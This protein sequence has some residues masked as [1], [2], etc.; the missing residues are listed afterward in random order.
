MSQKEGLDA[1]GSSI[2]GAPFVV[3][4]QNRHVTWGETT[5][6]FDVT[7]TYQERIQALPPGPNGRRSSDLLR[8][9]CRQLEHGHPVRHVPR[10][11]G[12]RRPARQPVVACGRRGI[13]PVVLTVPRRNNGPIVDLRSIG[14]RRRHGDQRPVHRFQRHARARDVPAAQP[15]AQRHEFV[16]ALQY[17]DVG[18][19][20]F[21]YGDIDGNIGYFSTAK[22]RCART[23][24]PS[25][26]DGSPPWFIRNGQGGNEWLQ[27]PDPTR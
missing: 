4:G 9:A 17:F 18:S 16:A 26:V 19:Q 1:I 3:L 22:C 10:Q 15:R 7:D 6:G 27:G 5:T 25:T 14:R 12:R 21:I 2:A 11:H 8:W 24:R 23:C 20:N 13:P